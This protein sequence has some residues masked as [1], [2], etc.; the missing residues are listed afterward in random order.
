MK[1][2]H[3]ASEG[4]SAP[5]WYTTPTQA[6]PSHHATTT[7]PFHNNH[8]KQRADEGPPT[9]RAHTHTRHQERQWDRHRLEAQLRGVEERVYR[10]PPHRQHV[11][12][13][14]LE[15]GLVPEVETGVQQ[16]FRVRGWSCVHV[17]ESFDCGH[18]WKLSQEF[19]V[20]SDR[21]PL[22][23][24]KITPASWI[25]EVIIFWYFVG[26]ISRNI[27]SET[28]HSG[29]TCWYSAGW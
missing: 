22:I 2:H 18:D 7:Q 11:A 28:R 3:N 13:L 21:S 19:M 4:Q 17:M 15:G 5:L 6:G 25:T 29:S 27:N 12:D 23:D 20:D 9:T 16:Q 26:K 10:E 14:Q 24:F 1:K 8:T